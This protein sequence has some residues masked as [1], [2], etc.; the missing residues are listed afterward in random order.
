MANIANNDRVAF[1]LRADANGAGALTIEGR[2]VP[3]ASL[4]P[5]DLLPEYLEKYQAGIDSLGF[6][7]SQF[8]GEYSS[9]IRIRVTRMRAFG[10]RHLGG[11]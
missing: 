3:D 6:T 7:A 1:N 8:A 11:S 10:V 5:A 2:A 9:G 4:P